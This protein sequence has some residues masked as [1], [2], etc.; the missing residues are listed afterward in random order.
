MHGSV[1]NMVRSK[2]EMAEGVVNVE[3]PSA[4]K[5][6]EAKA[7]ANETYTVASESLVESNLRLL[8]QGVSLDTLESAMTSVTQKTHGGS[9]TQV[10]QQAL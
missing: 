3:M 5:I 9:L 10:L 1:F 7:Q 8:P 4:Q 2:I 6:Q